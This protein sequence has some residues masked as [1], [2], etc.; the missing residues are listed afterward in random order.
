MSREHETALL[1]GDDH[2]SD[3]YEL[4]HILDVATAYLEAGHVDDAEDLLQEALDADPQHPGVISLTRRLAHIRG[5]QNGPPEPESGNTHAHQPHVIVNFTVPLPGTSAQPPSIQRLVKSA[6]QHYA[7]GHINSALDLT[8]VVCAEAPDFL[9]GFVRLAELH[10]ALDR[11]DQARE[12]LDLLRRRCAFD[13]APVPWPVEALSISLNPEDSS[14]LIGYAMTLF[15]AGDASMLDP[16][17][18]AAIARA[19]DMNVVAAVGLAERYLAMKPGDDNAER[20]FLT[21][22][23]AAGNIEKLISSARRMVHQQSPPDLLAIRVGS[24]L[25]S[26]SPEWLD[27]LEVLLNSVRADP[28]QRDLV[29]TTWDSAKVTGSLARVT[30]MHALLDMA[31]ERWPESLALLDNL[32]DERLSGTQERFVALFAR[33][34]ILKHL[35][36]PGAAPLLLEAAQ[37]AYASDIE[38]FARS[39]TLFGVSAAPTQMLRAF[40]LSDDGVLSLQTLIEL[41]DAN[42]SRLDIRSALADAFLAAGNVNDAIREMRYVAQECER[43]GNLNGMIEAMRSISMAVPENVEMKAKLIEGYLRRGVLNE[44]I[45]ELELIGALYLEQHRTDDA[46]A[47]FTKAAEISSALGDFSRGNDLFDRAV[48]ADPDN[49]PVRH[50]AVAFYLQTGA[51]GKATEQ[52]REVVRIALAADDRDEAVAALHQIIALAPHDPA[53]YH[54][55]GEVL[56]SLGEFTQAE[57]V[58][59]RLATFTP[60]DPVLEAKQSALAVLAATK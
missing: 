57:R 44:A 3:D 41:R 11:V 30:L 53:A 33:A 26:D 14:A 18:P 9:S 31:C 58:Y 49:V 13:D 36:D 43:S 29:V 21:V 52:L 47:A 48:L 10:I 32:D 54:S 4:I 51:V 17:V 28:S 19:V 8:F 46:V 45:D 60:H 6:E 25:A 16:F 24:E 56:T 22:L 1:S 7:A 12:T 55:L 35:G 40:A 50:A 2:T 59:R 34:T 23:S 39:T 42:P 5:G 37:A 27:W 15:D 38:P 20:L